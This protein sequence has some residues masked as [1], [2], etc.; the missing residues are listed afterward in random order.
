VAAP[1]LT[2]AGGGAGALVR[3]AAVLVVAALLQ[4]AVLDG[5]VVAGAHPDLFP[6]L[7]AAAGLVAGPQRGAVAAFAAGLV[8]DLFV[9]TP[10]GLSALAFVLVAFG[11]GL[12]ADAPVDRSSPA[13]RLLA[14]VGGSVACTIAFALVAGL[15][16]QPGMVG[17]HV[18]LVAS[19]VGAGAVLLGLPA[20]AALRW[21]LVGARR[22]QGLGVPLGG[23]A[24]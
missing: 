1:G 18:V 14:V 9:D 17:V 10:Y 11:V 2:G 15:L 5:L 21:A 4:V 24:R 7:A 12:L 3:L 16:G 22:Q 20:V 13:V 19:V 8:A 6:V 23:S